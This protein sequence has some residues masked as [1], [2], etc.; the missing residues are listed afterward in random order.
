MGFKIRNAQIKDIPQMENIC[1]VTGKAGS[2][3]SELYNN[4]RL[5]GQIYCTPYVMYDTTPCLVVADDNDD[6]HGY[7]IG[8]FNTE[9]F[10]KWVNEEFFPNVDISGENKTEGEANLKSIIKKG[11][12]LSD[13][14][15]EYTSHLHID[16]LPSLQGQGM[17]RKLM[18]A[19]WDILKNN[20]VKKLSLG[21]SKENI[22]AFH[23]YQKLGFSILKNESWGYIFGK[24]L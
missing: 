22:G 15:K 2:D 11:L 14:D 10:Y 3:A 7:I 23:F 16:L 18:E 21:M 4:K 13:I 8:C 6:V 17:G 5:L 9:K 12:I 24:E 1:L 19:F 20:G